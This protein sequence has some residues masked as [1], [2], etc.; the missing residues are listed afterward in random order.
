MT[1]V[2]EGMLLAHLDGQ[3][4]EDREEVA[5]H[6]AACP[7]CAAELRSL[8]DMTVELHSALTLGDVAAPV[9]AARA[10]VFAARSTPVLEIGRGVRLGRF[11]VGLLQAASLALVLAGVVGAAIPGTPLRLWVE[12]VIAAVTGETPAPATTPV[13]VVPSS[14]VAAEPDVVD[15]ELGVRAK[16][17]RIRVV[18]HDPPQNARLLIGLGD[19]DLATISATAD[20]QTSAGLMEAT[21]IGAGDINITLP[22]RGVTG[23][24]EVNGRIL[25]R[26][27][28]G[29]YT[30]IAPGA[31]VQGEV[32]TLRIS[33]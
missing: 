18:L 14:P 4:G 7:I 13:Q 6:L 26:R 10:A 21:G 5:A 30:Y 23:T 29:Q 25:V 17:G 11:R 19:E 24:V 16:D 1:H 33:R 8:R 9:A 3:S 32:I 20:F 2:D 27:E 28:A 22:R 12:S 31:T 15:E